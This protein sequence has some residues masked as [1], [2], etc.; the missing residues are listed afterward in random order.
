[1][2][3]PCVVEVHKTVDQVTLFKSGDVGQMVVVYGALRVRALVATRSKIVCG[4]SNRIVCALVDTNSK[5]LFCVS[6]Q[7][8]DS[9]TN[10]KN[11]PQQPTKR[12]CGRTSSASRKSG[13]A[14]GGRGRT[15]ADRRRRRCGSS[16]T[17]TPRG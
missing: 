3:L 17:I 7:A 12:R 6:H 11:N 5:S 10:T 9:T 2:N 1:M 16:W 4:Q 13:S 14:R 8:I 15:G